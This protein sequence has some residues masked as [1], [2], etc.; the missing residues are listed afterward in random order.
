[1]QS[2]QPILV[3]SELGAGTRGSSLG[4]LSVMTADFL[5]KGSFSGMN[6]ETV[7]ETYPSLYSFDGE[8]R[9]KRIEAIIA[10]TENISKAVSSACR[11]SKFPFV[12]SGDHSNAYGTISG[13]KDFLGAKKLGVVWID[14]HAD[15]HTPF[16]TPSGNMHGMPLGMAIGKD[17]GQTG[18]FSDQWSSLLNISGGTPKIEPIDIAFIAVRETEEAENGVI[19]QNGIQNIRVDELRSQGIDLAVERTLERL[20]HCDHIYISFD[21]DSMDPDMVSRGTGTPV[22][23][24]ITLD[25][26]IELNGKLA[27]DPRVICWEM[28]EVNPL[29]DVENKMAKSALQVA[30]QVLE[31]IKGRS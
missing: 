16:T 31:E 19:D 6:W 27:R 23:H 13:L 2:I 28:T 7:P 20:S 5:E 15:L 17:I 25:E 1:M 26:A 24:G 12:F 8:S 9:A 11:G 4:P 21:V 14:A 18:E 29:L 30:Y 22:P 10:H 3:R